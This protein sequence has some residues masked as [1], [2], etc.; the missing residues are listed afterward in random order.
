LL[1]LASTSKPSR[2]QPLPPLTPFFTSRY[3]LLT[4][5]LSTFITSFHTHLTGEYRAAAK[6]TFPN[7]YATA[8][9]AATSPEKYRFNCAQKAHANFTE[10][11]TSFVTV[12]LIAGL[13]YPKISTALGAT[14]VLARVL[15][16]LGYTRKYDA[17]DG[18]GRHWG[19]WWALPHMA[20]MGFAVA[21]SLQSL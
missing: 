8:V 11:H 14:W 9:E 18:K 3:V 13:K 17:E 20:L 2:T 1:F 16:V 19:S 4:A 7:A 5:T 21:S 12:L 15:Y 6:V 10:N